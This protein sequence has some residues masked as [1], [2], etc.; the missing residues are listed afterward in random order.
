MVNGRRVRGLRGPARY[1]GRCR[2]QPA[3]SSGLGLLHHEPALLP[4]QGADCD[5]SGGLIIGPLWWLS[6]RRRR[7]GSTCMAGVMAPGGGWEREVQL[8]QGILGVRWVWSHVGPP[9][10]RSR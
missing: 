4:P 3:G 7:L 2:T 5:A 9:G 8:E 1:L 10:D 6:G